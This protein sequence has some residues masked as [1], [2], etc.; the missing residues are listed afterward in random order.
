MDRICAFV[1]LLAV[2][3]SFAHAEVVV[4]TF[5]EPRVELYRQ[6]L[7]AATASCR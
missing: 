7:E 6:Q 2:S 3:P 4:R 1:V 5:D